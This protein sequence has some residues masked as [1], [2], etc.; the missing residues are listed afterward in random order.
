MDLTASL[1]V[2]KNLPS[3][4]ATTPL[5]RLS[6]RTV[7][8]AR[9]SPVRASVTWPRTEVS[10]WAEAKRVKKVKMPTK[11]GRNEAIVFIENVDARKMYRGL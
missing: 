3:R 9:P 10:F 5:P 11:T 4:S 8:F 1:D 2:I 6:K 7:A